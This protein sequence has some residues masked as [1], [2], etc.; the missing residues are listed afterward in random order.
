MAF[1]R[2][3]L[4]SNISVNRVV[5]SGG[6]ESF[7]GRD[8]LQTIFQFNGVQVMYCF[9]KLRVGCFFGSGSDTIFIESKS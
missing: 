8:L 3:S 4:A 1:V 7:Q 5:F 9:N 2:I 6:G